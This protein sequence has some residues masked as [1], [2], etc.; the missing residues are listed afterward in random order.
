MQSPVQWTV[1]SCTSLVIQSGLTSH[2]FKSCRDSFFRRRHFQMEVLQPPTCQNSPYLQAEAESYRTAKHGIPALRL[3][4]DWS[5]RRAGLIF[6]THVEPTLSLRRI[7]QRCSRERGFMPKLKLCCGGTKRALWR[8][9]Y[10]ACVCSPLC[11][12]QGK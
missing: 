9:Q 8:H 4:P 11:N 12:W 6:A 10:F 3:Q 5:D 1:S 2:A 7:S